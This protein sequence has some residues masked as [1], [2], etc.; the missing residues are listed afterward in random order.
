[1]VVGSAS[2]LAVACAEADGGVRVIGTVAPGFENAPADAPALPTLD[3]SELFRDPQGTYT[4]SIGPDWARMP[5]TAAQEIEFWALDPS[6]VGFAD[7]VNVLTQDT[8]GMGLGEYMDTSA[9]SM[10]NLV[11][12]DQYKVVGTNGNELGVLESRGT[13]F[14]APTDEPLHFLTVVDVLDGVAIVATL[15]ATLDTFDARRLAA[16]PYLLTLQAI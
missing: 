13:P 8:L 4:M 15:S 16:E 10:G 6:Q 5:G 9:E 2:Q 7:N 1:M 12:L 11:V 14:G 3:Q